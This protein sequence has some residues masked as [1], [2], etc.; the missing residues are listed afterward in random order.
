MLTIG[1]KKQLFP[2]DG[3]MNLRDPILDPI[4]LKQYYFVYT[5]RDERDDD[6]A[7]A[8]LDF[9]QKASKA[10]GIKLDKPNFIDIKVK[11]GQRLTAKDWIY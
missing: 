4:H 5:S 3:S 11:R 7:D 8:T 10:F 2:K 9:L 6:D 1:N